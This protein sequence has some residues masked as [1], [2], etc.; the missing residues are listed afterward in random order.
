MPRV[1]ETEGYRFFFYSNEHTPAHVHVRKGDGEAVFDLD[2]VV[3]LRTAFGMKS[4]EVQRA[5]E[6]ALA[7]REFILRSWNE[8]IERQG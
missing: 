8:H 2:A 1:I 4:R 6:L 3:N 7:H 5:K